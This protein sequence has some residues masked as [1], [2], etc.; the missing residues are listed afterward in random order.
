MN[1]NQDAYFERLKSDL[2]ELLAAI[3]PA[4]DGAELAEAQEKIDH[5]EYAI[6]TQ[7]LGACVVE[8]KIQLD[9]RTVQKMSDLIETMGMKD[10]ADEDFWFWQEMQS[11]FAGT[12]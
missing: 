11:Y 7:V 1:E 6:A 4:I 12:R 3:A 10:A 9:E 5:G 8:R 2:S